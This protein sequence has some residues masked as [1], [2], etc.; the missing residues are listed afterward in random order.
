M[1]YDVQDKS[2]IKHSVF[3]S[4]FDDFYK[5]FN[6][7][8]S[9]SEFKQAYWSLIAFDYLLEDTFDFSISTSDS[10]S[11]RISEAKIYW[12]IWN[13]NESDKCILEIKPDYQGIEKEYS[14]NRILKIFI[15]CDSS[16]QSLKFIEMIN[17]ALETAIEFVKEQGIDY[18][19]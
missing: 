16:S 14:K 12:I 11:N 18:I 17:V 1:K 13:K 6:S 10:Y 5:Q 2:K 4:F 9:E 7:P 19:L 15:K 8:K 3:I